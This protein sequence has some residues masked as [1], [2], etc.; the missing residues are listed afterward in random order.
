[1]FR[2]R[3]YSTDTCLACFDLA[4]VA[5]CYVAVMLLELSPAET[6]WHLL[7]RDHLVGLGLVWV[8]WFGLSIYFGLYKSRR[9]DSPLADLGILLKTALACWVLLEGVAHQVAWLSPTSFFLTCFVIVNFAGLAAARTLLR[10]VLREFR[11]H[12][13][14]VKQIVLVTS[15]ELGQR[16]A[17]KIEQRAHYGY[18]ILR[19][20]MYVANDDDAGHLLFQFRSCLQSSH[21][22]DV[23]VGLPAH[24]NDLAAQL[25]AECENHG[26]NVRI[27]PDLFPIIQT[28]TQM[29]DLDGIPLVNVRLYPAEYFGYAICKRVFDVVFSLLILVLLSPGFF[30]IALLIRITSPGP[31]FFIQERVG[32]NGRK[33]KMLKFRTMR[34]DSS[35]DPDS[36]WTVR[37]DPHITRLGRWL[38]ISN[39]DE[40]PQFINVLKGDMSV[41]GP[42]PERP[43]FLERFRREIPEYMARHYVKSGIT[44]W[45]QVN[46]WRGDTAIA[47]RV[48]HDLYYVQHWGLTLDLKILVLTLFRTF[49]H[50]NAY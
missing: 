48:A 11:R 25:V 7:A 18:R 3:A 6:S 10:L 32:L 43:F 29:Y 4:V 39:L 35:L 31:L 17:G 22:D 47:E 14:D 38:R 15:P 46:G 50:G 21:I 42:R 27:V 13:R 33:F 1:M 44:G 12:G 37:N 41:V 26:I 45:A 28:D 20:F 16:L 8:I 34:Q 19:E 49:F 5:C 30:L 24:A 36:H 40:L 23:I 2:I 9:L